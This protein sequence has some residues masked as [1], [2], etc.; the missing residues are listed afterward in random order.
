M[1]RSLFFFLLIPAI[2][3]SQN[4]TGQEIERF[5]SQ[6]ERVTIVR[7]QWDIPHIY[8]HSDAD[9]VF[10]LLYA[11]CEENFSR[12]E[13]NYLEIM[14]RMSEVEGRGQLYQDLQM[15]LI[16]DSAAAIAD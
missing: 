11:Q 16:Y 1:K 12:V 3:F 14:G 5:K 2:S 7:D 6:A 13:K 10:G 15:R 4:F 9:A 8:G